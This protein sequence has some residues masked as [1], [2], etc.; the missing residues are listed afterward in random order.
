VPVAPSS[1]SVAH[2]SLA[3]LA[4]VAILALAIDRALAVPLSVKVDAGGPTTTSSALG[5]LVLSEVM[6]GGAGASDEF[7]ELYNPTS[8]TQPLEGLEVV[9]VTSTGATVTRKAA[10]AA[11]AAGM[12]PGAHLLIANSAGIFGGLGDM[13]Y[14][15]GLAAAGGS[16]ALRVQAAATAIDAVGW[17][18]AASTWLETRPAPAAA[19]GSSL[20]RLPGGAVGSSQDTDDNL[21]DFAIQPV[22]DPQ[23]SG[24]PP[25]VLATPSPLASGSPSPFATASASATSEPTAS[26]TPTAAPT[27]SITPSETPSP[28]PSVM[29]TPSPSPTPAPTSTPTPIPTTSPTAT[30]SPLS[31][32][33]ARSQPDGTSVLVDGVAMTDGSF[34]DGGGYLVDGTAGIAVLIGDGTFARGQLLRIAGTVDDRYA[35]RTIRTSAAQITI[36]GSGSE[37]L[38]IDAETASVGEA[39]EG[40]LVELTGL[41]TSSATTLSTGVAWDLDDGSGPIRVVIGTATGIDTAGWGRGVGLT[42]IGV[43]GQRDSSGSGTAGFRVQPRDAADVIA[44]EPPAT[45]SPTPSPTVAPTVAPTPAPT[46]TPVASASA[47][48]SAAASSTATP[49]AVPLVSIGEGRAAATGTHLRIRGVVTAP[50]GLLEVGSAVV[51]DSTGAI[52]VRLGGR[53]G[54]L[55]LGQLVELDGVR[56]TKA[57]MLSLRVNTLPLRIGT[58]AD[59]TPIRRA[60]GAL[61][62]AEEARVVIARGKVSTAVSRPKGGAVSF[63][64][65][66]GSGPLRVTISSR[67]GIKT[68]AI[69]KGAW[70][71]LRGVL[72]QA[73]T[74]KAPLNGYRLWPR[75]RA[76]L[77]V[78]AIPVASAGSGRCCGGTSSGPHGGGGLTSPDQEGVAPG[79]A[80][81]PILARPHPTFAAAAPITAGQPTSTGHGAARGAG[82]LVSGMGVVALAALAAWFGRRRLGMGDPTAERDPAAPEPA[83][84]ASLPHLSLLRIEAEEA[85]EERRILPPT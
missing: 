61:G 10:W 6:T 47:S 33:T 58:Q 54:S 85:P 22:P 66:D 23:N 79:P 75:V 59:P 11:G 41:I 27:D 48:P 63:S 72:G 5:H 30:P 77:V 7:I 64:I 53:A 57:G 25:I 67:S 49:E 15:N 62:E 44:V 82:L 12:T 2:R 45:P 80:V 37:P 20:E 3:L 46:A 68:D 74:S 52:L 69:K 34:T 60:T 56:A 29:A 8:G 81:P 18:T 4:A 50:S 24:S 83:P 40:Q 39:L 1:P 35:Q 17:G 43:V 19:A 38:P 55:S 84:D 14:T 36:L 76:D 13:T 51:Q 32:A 31:I 21:V 28:S 70:L 16:V 9:Y 71:E 73:T 26:P 65:D 42:V 78:V